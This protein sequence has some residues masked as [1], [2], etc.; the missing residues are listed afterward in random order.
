MTEIAQELCEEYAEFYPDHIAGLI[1]RTVNAA[2]SAVQGGDMA[3][4]KAAAGLPDQWRTVLH[5]RSDFDAPSAC[6]AA[7]I[8]FGA[9]SSEIALEGRP[10]EALTFV[11]AS[12]S[13][14][15][16]KPYVQSGPAVEFNWRTRE[17]DEGSPGVQL[18]RKICRI[19]DLA[20]QRI[21]D[22]GPVAPNLF[23][24]RPQ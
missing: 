2:R 11:T 9:L 3:G 22:E 20:A 24:A 18:L 6:N 4:V 17:A 13:T 8:M 7:L 5:E 14:Y 16:G 21:A 12:V 10:K 19:A 15:P 23:S 1:R